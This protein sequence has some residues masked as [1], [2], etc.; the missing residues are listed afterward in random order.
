MLGHGY[1]VAVRVKTVLASLLIALCAA[2]GGP[3]QQEPGP[4]GGADEPGAGPGSGEHHPAPNA[5]RSGS[6]PNPSG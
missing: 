4:T 1:P 2:C 3:N 5:P 6:G